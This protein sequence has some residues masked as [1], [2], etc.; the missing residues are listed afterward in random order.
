MSRILQVRYQEISYPHAE[1][2]ILPTKWC[3]WYQILT[4]KQVKCTAHAKCIVI[5]Q[6]KI[7]ARILQN[8]F[9]SKLV[10]IRKLLS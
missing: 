7:S 8:N 5:S 1:L 2:C 6:K 4:R 3:I 9:G 10:P